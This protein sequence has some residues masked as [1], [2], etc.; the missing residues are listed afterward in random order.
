MENKFFSIPAAVYYYCFLPALLIM[1]I[2]LI[3]W[4][5][6]RH[7]KDTYY[8]TF[9][10]NYF[11]QLSGII[12]SAMMLALLLGYSVA[13]IYT[14]YV[15]DLV[16]NYYFFMII[17]IFL[18]IIPLCLFIWLIFK[19]IR[20]LKYKEKLDENYDNYIKEQNNDFQ[21]DE[22]ENEKEIAN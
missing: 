4:L 13:T 21:N 20:T 16:A 3:F 18:P 1:I 12:L 14:I 7:K 22:M 15:N 5:M 10:L 19:L 2:C 17:L 11:F 9:T 6:Y 8:Y